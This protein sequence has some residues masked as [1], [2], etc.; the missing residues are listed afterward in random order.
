MFH[1]YEFVND[2]YNRPNLVKKFG[3]FKNRKINNDPLFFEIEFDKL[4]K[5]RELQDHP[6]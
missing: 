1:G 2:I 6:V 3:E 5:E 4:I